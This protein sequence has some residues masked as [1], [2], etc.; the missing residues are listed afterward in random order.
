MWNWNEFNHF[1]N[2]EPHNPFNWTNVELK[3]SKELAD[4]CP[5]MTFNWTNVELKPASSAVVSNS[6]LAFNWTNVELKQLTAQN[7]KMQRKNF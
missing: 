6:S 7:K 4:A 2:D 3:Q 5:L 1:R